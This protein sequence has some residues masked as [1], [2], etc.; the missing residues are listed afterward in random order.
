MLSQTGLKVEGHA[1]FNIALHRLLMG[2]VGARKAVVGVVIVVD[3]V[4][5]VVGVVVV[6]VVCVIAAV[7]T[8]APSCAFCTL[9]SEHVVLAK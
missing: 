9:L 1:V 5:V 2:F 4:V 6:G 7:V 8:H 3:V